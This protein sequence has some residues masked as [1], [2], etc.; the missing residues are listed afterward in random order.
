[1][2]ALFESESSSEVVVV[3]LN[4]AEM[5]SRELGGEFRILGELEEVRSMRSCFVES[6]CEVVLCRRR[7]RWVIEFRLE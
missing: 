5:G 2:F 7:G 4:L 3:S 1:V 6:F